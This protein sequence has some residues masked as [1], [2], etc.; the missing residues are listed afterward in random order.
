MLRGDCPNSGWYVEEIVDTPSLHEAAE[1]QE[2]LWLADG[3]ET[4]ADAVV[5]EGDVLARLPSSMH[6]AQNPIASGSDAV[7]QSLVRRATLTRE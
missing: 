3:F 7:S 6:S 1:L 5:R 2:R 4:L